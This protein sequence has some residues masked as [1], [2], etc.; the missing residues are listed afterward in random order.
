MGRNTSAMKRGF[1]YDKANSKL[2]VMVD[3]TEVL[4]LTTTTVTNNVAQTNTG[5]QTFTAQDV[6]N[7]GLTAAS[8]T[9]VVQGMIAIPKTTVTALTS[10]AGFTL[11]AAQVVGGLVVDATATGAIAMPLPTVAACVALIPGYVVGSSFWFVY[12]NSGNQTTTIATDASTQWTIEG[13]ATIV[14]KTTGIWLMVVA[15][16]TTGT[17]YRIGAG[18]TTA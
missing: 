14:T 1:N 5:V 10:G 16:G 6:H 7:A 3:G 12:K 11:S 9:A 2:A 17:A 13:L 8:G 15:S 4:G 18:I